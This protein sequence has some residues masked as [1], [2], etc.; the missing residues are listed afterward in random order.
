MEGSYSLVRAAAAVVGAAIARVDR[1]HAPRG[2]RSW[3]SRARCVEGAHA[4]AGRARGNTAR[5]AAV[6]EDAGAVV[7]VDADQ[8]VGATEEHEVEEHEVEEHEVEEHEVEEHE[9]EEHEVEEHQVEVAVA[10]EVRAGHAEAVL[11]VRDRR[12]EHHVVDHAARRVLAGERRDP[13]ARE[14]RDRACHSEHRTHA[15]RHE[16]VGVCQPAGRFE[17]RHASA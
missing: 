10:I 2:S 17:R 8:A 6:G 15:R 12:G 7:L 16:S 11:R 3:T 9:V 4:A 14:G 5:R 1:L 13:A